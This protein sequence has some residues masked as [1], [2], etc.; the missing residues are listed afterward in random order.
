MF[1]SW[2]IPHKTQGNSH[3]ICGRLIPDITVED[4]KLKEGGKDCY[5]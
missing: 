5:Q 2:H 3:V 4:D 1:F